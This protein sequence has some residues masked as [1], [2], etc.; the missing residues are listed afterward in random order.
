MA[1][2]SVEQKDA[3]LQLIRVNIKA[4]QKQKYNPLITKTTQM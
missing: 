1:L 3:I 2:E 4:F